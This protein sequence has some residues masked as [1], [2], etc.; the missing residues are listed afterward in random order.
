MVLVDSSTWVRVEHERISLADVAPNETVAV[1]PVV[2]L[3]VLRGARQY[4]ATRK[5]LMAVEI[6]D[7]PT[8]L[9]RFEEAA[10]LYRECRKAGVTPSAVDC[11][12]AACAI[13]HG[14]TLVHNDAD[15]EHIAH[16]TGLKL[17]TRS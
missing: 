12:V 14:I 11:L 17:F 1:C 15:F 4:A 13:A 9:A 3:E 6:L 2:I 16:V 8:P 7:D 10:R 5:M